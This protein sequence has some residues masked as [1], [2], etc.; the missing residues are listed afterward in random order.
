MA[1]QQSDTLK[2][3]DTAPD[4]SLSAANQPG[5]FTLAEAHARGPAIVEFLR[6]TW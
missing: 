6:G 2:M 5:L 4:F 1:E 3:G